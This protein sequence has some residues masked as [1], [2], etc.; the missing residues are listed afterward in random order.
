V[1]AW[2]PY[3]KVLHELPAHKERQRDTSR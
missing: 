2:D 3:L 1:S